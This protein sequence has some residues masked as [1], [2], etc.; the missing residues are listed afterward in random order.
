MGQNVSLIRELN[1]LRR[2]IKVRA[3]RACNR[4]RG[5]PACRLGRL[6]RPALE[7][8]VQLCGQLLLVSL[9]L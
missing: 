6:C 5:E 7:Q 8:G 1:E 3:W 4:G 2:E 9:M